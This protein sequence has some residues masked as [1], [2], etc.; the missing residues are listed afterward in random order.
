LISVIRRL[1]AEPGLFER[2]AY[3]DRELTG[4]AENDMVGANWFLAVTE[5]PIELPLARSC[6]IGSRG[7]A[8]AHRHY[9]EDFCLDQVISENFF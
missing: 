1:C 2:V 6:D 7:G 5:E 8:P 9:R 3:F 4:G